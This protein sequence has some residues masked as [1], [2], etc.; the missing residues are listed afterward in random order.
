MDDGIKQKNYGIANN[1]LHN[2][3]GSTN[4]ARYNINS[5]R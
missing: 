1:L 5:R 2:K 4:A 3:P